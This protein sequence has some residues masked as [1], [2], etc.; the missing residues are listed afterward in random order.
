MLM[1]LNGMALKDS[2]VRISVPK[3]AKFK[4]AVGRWG[5]SV[6]D[7]D[8]KKIQWKDET[9]TLEQRRVR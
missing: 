3:A 6:R 7:R 5:K 8:E 9:F 4:S 2:F 1:A